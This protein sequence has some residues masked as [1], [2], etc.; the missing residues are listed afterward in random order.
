[1]ARRSTTRS[2]SLERRRRGGPRF[3]LKEVSQYRFGDLLPFHLPCKV[4]FC[5]RIDIVKFR[6]AATPALVTSVTGPQ[7]QE[8]DKVKKKKLRDELIA[9]VLPPGDP[10]PQK[11]WSKSIPFDFCPAGCTCPKA[12]IVMRPAEDTTHTYEFT[13]SRKPPGAKP[14]APAKDYK[15]KV[16]IKVTRQVGFANCQ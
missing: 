4:F 7:G 15:V 5:G 11:N 16:E 6:E 12:A 13:V 9:E 1:M 3:T 10:N 14:G 2:R 8:I